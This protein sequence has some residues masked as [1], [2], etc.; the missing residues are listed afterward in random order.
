MI[1]FMLL[2]LILIAS[3]I[4]KRVV[5]DPSFKGRLGEKWV[6]KELKK[7]DPDRYIVMN[8]LLLA[9]TEGKTTQIDHVVVSVFGVFVIEM[10][11][12]RGRIYGQED[13]SKWTQAF[14]R[15]KK[16]FYN[17]IRQ[18]RGHVRAIQ[19]LLADQPQLPVSSIIVFSDKA[20]LKLETTTP[21]VSFS[22][23]LATIRT[24][25]Q[26]ML[27][28]EQA[29]DI[30]TRIQQACIVGNKARKQHVQNI[31]QD[32]QARQGFVDNGICPS[33]GGELVE[34]AGKYGRFTGCSGYPKCRFTVK[35]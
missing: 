30:A 24:Y 13:S 6:A 25:Q 8:D 22:R 28:R 16:Q 19:D 1:G 3:L 27:T 32:L 21:V 4:L 20:Q 14:G 34:R 31:K 18:N 11:N 29:V 9:T 23:L 7:L 5:N 17:P 10:K 15:S 26:P 35:N 33:C 12:Y 2:F